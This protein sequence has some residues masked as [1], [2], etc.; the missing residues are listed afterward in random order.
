[1][2]IAATNRVVS[3]VMVVERPEEGKERPVQRPVYYLSEVLTESKQ[4]YPQYRKLVYAVFRATRRLPHY[5][6]E[7][8][9]T[10][11]S[12]GP[13]ADIIRNRDA[14]GRV[15]KW[16]VEIGVHNI[17]Y[18][19]RRAIKSQALA[20]FLVDWE[21]TQLPEPTEDQQGW[22][23]H[24]DGSKAHEGAGAGIVLTSPKGD[25]LKYALQLT[26]L[27]C[28]NNVAEY[29]A[30]L[31]GMRVAKEMGVSRLRCF[32]DSDLVA[33]QVMGTCDATDPNMIAYRRAVDQLGGS[34]AGYSVEWI[35]RRKNEEA[36]ALSRVGSSK[37]PPPA[38]VFLDKLDRPSVL[39]L[40]RCENHDIG[41]SYLL[42]SFGIGAAR[43]Q[44]SRASM[45]NMV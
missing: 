33:S 37:L 17:K 39:P 6:Q 27:P 30:L 12:S 21:E 44:L 15:A 10:V 13:L 11:V 4:R 32:G 19:P 41:G 22:T 9:I 16:A 28:T 1:M 23:L 14:T 3:T 25:K 36:D 7:H 35:D 24:F 45:E 18:E 8:P 31:H 42:G 20:D 2:Y 26:F 29:E 34:F 38:D 43:V 5:F 40:S